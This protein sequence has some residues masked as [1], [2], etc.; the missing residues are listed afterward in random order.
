MLTIRDFSRQLIYLILLVSVVGS[1]S[2]SIVYG[3]SPF[4]LSYIQRFFM[5]SALIVVGL[6]ILFNLRKLIYILVPLTLLGALAS[7]YH[8]HYLLN[9]SW[10]TCG[11]ALP[12]QTNS[13]I[14][15]G[16][17][18]LNPIYLPSLAFCSFTIVS[19]LTLLTEPKE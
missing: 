6:A 15:W 16:P 4:L 13:R 19:I 1:L 3:W 2:F 9:N 7:F 14:L 5:Y 17:I 8:F 11:F 12:C 10:A 18:E